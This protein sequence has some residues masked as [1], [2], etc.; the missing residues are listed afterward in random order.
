MLMPNGIANALAGERTKTFSATGVSTPEQKDWRTEGAVT[1]VKDQGQCGSCWA[2]ST[3]GTLESAWFL[4][5][6]DLPTLSEQN[7]MDCSWSYGNMACNGGMPDRALR[8][9]KKNG[10]IDTEESY[11]YEMKSH[12]TCKY[13]EDAI[14]AVITHST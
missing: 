10:G 1:P 9:V 12:F 5:G 13:D 3:T 6:H 2:F 8:Y 14:G 7:L 11:P 4:A